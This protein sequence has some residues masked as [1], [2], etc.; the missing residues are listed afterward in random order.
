MT[1][2]FM[3][4]RAGNEINAEKMLRIFFKGYNM[5]VGLVNNETLLA[6]KEQ[7]GKVD[8]EDRADVFVMFTKMLHKRH[9]DF[10]VKQ[11]QI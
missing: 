6:L 2:D 1:M 5:D 10:N 4:K 9:I 8:R 7:F 3:T 11:F